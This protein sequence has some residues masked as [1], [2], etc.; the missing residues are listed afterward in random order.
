MVTKKTIS[1]TITL[2][3]TTNQSIG[4][5]RLLR[6]G[7]EI[8]KSLENNEQATFLQLKI[9][10]FSLVEHDFFNFYSNLKRN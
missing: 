7:S 9:E 6:S 1:S 5:K 3:G 8:K 10:I 2:W 4:V